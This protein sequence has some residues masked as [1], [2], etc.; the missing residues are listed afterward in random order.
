[1][2]KNVAMGFVNRVLENPL[3]WNLSQFVLGGNENKQKLYRSLFTKKG[4]I[5]DFGCAD[6]NTFEAFQ[7]FDYYGVD[8]D[9]KFINYA[10]QKF[11]NYSN[12]HWLAVDI[13]NGPFEKNTFDYVLFAGTGHH[14]SND[15]ICPILRSLIDLII[16]GGQLYIVDIISNPISDNWWKKLLIKFDQGQFTR[17][18][19]QYMNILYSM[20]DQVTIA[21]TSIRKM[22]GNFFPLPDFFIAVLEKK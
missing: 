19:A 21:S 3:V 13:L 4:K 14:I 15:M 1:M 12:A 7:D 8:I 18:E 10:R 9:S 16:C 6:G 5:L 2:K 22:K 17:T 11:K 20:Q